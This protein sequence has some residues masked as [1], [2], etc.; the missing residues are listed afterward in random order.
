MGVRNQL[1]PHLLL[2]FF[3]TKVSN[4][5]LRGGPKIFVYLAVGLF[6]SLLGVGSL[7]RRLS[8]ETIGPVRLKS[9]YWTKGTAWATL[10]GISGDGK[11]KERDADNDAKGGGLR[12]VVFGG[13]DIAT[14]ELADQEGKNDKPGGWTEKLCHEV[15]ELRTHHTFIFHTD[16]LLSFVARVICLL[17]RQDQMED[18]LWSRMTFMPRF[19]SRR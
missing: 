15:R 3:H 16:T 17:S 6:V 5:V 19:S 14:P 8:G 18:E 12:I 10:Q 13:R 11:G 4:R 1:S 7:S 9:W 2:A